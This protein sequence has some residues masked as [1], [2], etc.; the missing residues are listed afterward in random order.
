MAEFVQD[1]PRCGAKSITFDVLGDSPT[2][3]S[4]NSWIFE[5]LSRCRACSNCSVGVFKIITEG[6][7]QYSPGGITSYNGALTFLDFLRFVSTADRVTFPLPDHLPDNVANCFREGGASY[8]IGAYNAAAA[9]FRLALDLGTKG[10]LPS[11]PAEEGGPNS[12]QR[13][14][15]FDRLNYLFDKRLIAPELADLAD[16]VRED[17]NDGAHDGTLGKADAEDLVDFTQQLL[18]RV[19]SEPARLRIAKAR[20]EARRAEA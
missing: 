7:G 20:R 19:Y 6:A 17:G 8:N 1:C 5:T 2:G 4:D 16:C 9:M 11:E 14:R 18:E 3:Y 12:A 10:L 13:K 15:L